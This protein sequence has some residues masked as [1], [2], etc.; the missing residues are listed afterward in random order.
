MGYAFTQDR[1]LFTTTSLYL[2][3]NKKDECKVKT[4]ARSTF[5]YANR[6]LLDYGTHIR[7]YIPTSLSVSI[8][9]RQS[10]VYSRLL[11]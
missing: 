3:L 9:F 1:D 11:T 2:M 5:S 4:R 8:T 6:D 10:G 7:R